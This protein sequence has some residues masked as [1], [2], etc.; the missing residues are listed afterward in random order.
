MYDKKLK[1]D[2]MSAK[3]R[4]KRRVFWGCLIA[5]VS[6]LYGDFILRTDGYFISM[7]HPSIRTISGDLIRISV[8]SSLLIM[9]LIKLIGSVTM[10]TI[11]RKIGIWALSGIWAG[12]FVQ[13][14]IFSFGIGYPSPDY[15]FNGCIMAACF[16]V[17]WRGDYR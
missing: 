12:L 10:K 7:V 2:L 1:R 5:C 17:S 13:S 6:I 4:K 3:R 9:G 11:L 8:G 15:I 16:Y 14:L